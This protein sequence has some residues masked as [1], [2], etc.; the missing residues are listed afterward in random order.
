[1]KKLKLMSFYLFLAIVLNLILPNLSQAIIGCTTLQCRIDKICHEKYGYNNGNTAGFC[2]C[3][4]SCSCSGG[5]G[6]SCT[7]APSP[8]PTHTVSAKK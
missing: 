1:M 6:S 7:G 2:E 8:T 3:G 4:G 5:A